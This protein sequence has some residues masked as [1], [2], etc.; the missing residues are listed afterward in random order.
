MPRLAEFLGEL[1]FSGYQEL[2]FDRILLVEGP[3]DVK[4]MQ[5]FLRKYGKDHQ[6]VIMPL[7]GRGSINGAAEE[8]L[9]EITRITPKVHAVIDSEKASAGAMLEPRISDFQAA[10][11][12]AGIDCKVTDL[13]ATENY[14]SDAAVKEVKGA[15]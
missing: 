2:G 6:V 15:L 12:R 5:Q 9:I 8:Q 10:C 3:T 4:V 13:R 1:S 11:A 14:L 7:G